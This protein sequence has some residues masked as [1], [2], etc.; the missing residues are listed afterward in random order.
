MEHPSQ[1]E[2]QQWKQSSKDW[3]DD[4]KATV[5]LR[6]YERYEALVRVHVTPALGKTKL[7]R[8]EPL[9]I[10]R[11]YRRLMDGGLSPTT[12]HQVHAVIYRAL[13]RVV[14]W[15][16]ISHNAAALVDPPR[17]NRREMKVQH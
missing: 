14:R 2:T 10:Q 6:T 7:A 3:L 8:L 17:V 16:L 13:S 12:V 4:A 9:T 5:R 11:L 15:G 1:S